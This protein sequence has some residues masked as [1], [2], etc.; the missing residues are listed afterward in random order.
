M[1]FFISGIKACK[2]LLTFLTVKLMHDT[3]DALMYESSKNTE[4]LEGK[5]NTKTPLKFLT[6]N[7]CIMYESFRNTELPQ[8]KNTAVFLS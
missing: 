4:H 2:T 7:Y 1:L 5:Q 3:L 8:G 6:A